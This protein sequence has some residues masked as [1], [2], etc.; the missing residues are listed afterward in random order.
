MSTSRPTV[1]P[2][3]ALVGKSTRGRPLKPPDI[4]FESPPGHDIEFVLLT[5]LRMVKARDG[6]AALGRGD[7]TEP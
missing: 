5:A 2:A 3:T 1:T 7:R 4:R 6:P